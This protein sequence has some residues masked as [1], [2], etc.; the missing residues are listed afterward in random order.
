MTSDPYC[1]FCR[2]PRCEARVLVAGP[3][4][5]FICNECVEVAVP[6]VRRTADISTRCFVIDTVPFAALQPKEAA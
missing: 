3:D 2:K 4:N 5:L 1:S 6:L